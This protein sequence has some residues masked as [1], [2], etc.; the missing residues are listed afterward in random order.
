MKSSLIISRSIIHTIFLLISIFIAL[1][2][3]YYADQ[4]V[5]APIPDLILDHIP[6]IDTSLLYYQGAIALV[7]VVLIIIM[8]MPRYLPFTLAAVALFYLIRTGFMITTHLPAPSSTTGNDLFFSGHTGLPFLLSLIFY[9]YKI[10]HYFF[11]I[12]SVIAGSAVLL[13]HVH[14]T[15]DVLGAYFITYTI[16][17]IAKIVFKKEYSFIK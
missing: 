3:K 14:Y 10:P 9:K 17:E 1:L 16:Y 11:I 2:A 12:V 6:Y 4:F 8:R 15:I 5:G 7:V 13:S